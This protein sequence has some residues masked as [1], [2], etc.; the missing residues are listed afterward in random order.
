MHLGRYVSTALTELR[1]VLGLES[2]FQYVV[3]ECR[4]YAELDAPKVPEL[5]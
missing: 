3:S 1:Q 4:A 5:R 2:S